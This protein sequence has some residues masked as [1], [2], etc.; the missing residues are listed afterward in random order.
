MATTNLKKER[1]IEFT[2]WNNTDRPVPIDIIGVEKKELKPSD[3]IKCTYP[4]TPQDDSELGFWIYNS[5]RVML[6]LTGILPQN[7]TITPETGHQAFIEI[8][9]RAYDKFLI[10]MESGK[11]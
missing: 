7:W 6:E 10:K 9:K 5:D 4:I 1:T 11:L 3:S 2:I 8:V